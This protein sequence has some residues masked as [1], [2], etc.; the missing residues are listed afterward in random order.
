[1][2]GT[3]MPGDSLCIYA[4]GPPQSLLGQNYQ[5]CACTHQA[6]HQPCSHIQWSNSSG[7]E[8]HQSQGPIR[9]LQDDYKLAVS[10]AL[11]LNSDSSN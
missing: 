8:H 5:W 10:S 7:R 3:H 4:Q 2:E 11:P 1:M 6:R 9:E